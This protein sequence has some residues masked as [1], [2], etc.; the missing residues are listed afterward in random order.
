V[1]GRA[2]PAAFCAAFVSAFCA[3]AFGEQPLAPAEYESLEITY[4][5]LPGPKITETR[6]GRIRLNDSPALPLVSRF[7]L[8]MLNTAGE[9]RLTDLALVAPDGS[10]NAIPTTAPQRS[11]L[12]MFWEV[13]GAKPGDSVR[14]TVEQPVDLKGDKTRSWWFS[15]AAPLPLPVKS[16]VLRLVLPPGFRGTLDVLE[17]DGHFTGET[18]THSWK[19]DGL[20]AGRRAS[21]FLI[22][23][24]SDWEGFSTWVAE[25]CPVRSGDG[26]VSLSRALPTATG[27]EGRAQAAADALSRRL[28]VRPFADGQIGYGCRPVEE[29][30]QAGGANPLEAQ[31]VLV[32]LLREMRIAA[33]GYL[34]GAG[35]SGDLPVNPEKLTNVL[36]GVT[37]NGHVLWFDPMRLSGSTGSA[38]A[39]AMAEF[40]LALGRRQPAIW[41]PILPE[42]PG[43][44]TAKLDAA[45]T[46]RGTLQGDFV[47]TA[48]GPASEVYWESYRLRTDGSKGFTLLGPFLRDLGARSGPVVSDHND[49]GQPFRFQVPIHHEQFLTPIQ[50]NLPVKLNAIPLVEDPKPMPDG[51][52]FIGV[53][54]H[55]YEEIALT[56]P[57]G[58][59]VSGDVRIQEVRDFATYRSESVYAEGKLLIKRELE[60]RT[61]I[62]QASDRLA[63]DA[64][65]QLIRADQSHAFRLRRT[66]PMKVSEWVDSIAAYQAGQEGWKALEEGEYEIAR[67]LLERA[68]QANPKDQYAWNNL[69]RAL[70]AL[71]KI[72]E[73][74][75]AYEKQLEVS[76]K[77]QYAYSYLGLLFARQGY[78]DRAA[79]NYRKQLEVDPDDEYAS[80]NLAEALLESGRWGEA[81]EVAAKAAKAHPGSQIEAIAA[82]A[83]MCASGSSKALDEL[84]AAGGAQRS[85]VALNSAAYALA[86][87]GKELDRA[88][89]YME[90]AIEILE[91]GY[92]TSDKNISELLGFQ[93]AYGSYADTLGWIL[94]RKGEK[95]RAARLI[96]AAIGVAHHPEMMAH[97]ATILWDQGRKAEAARWAQEAVYLAPG[98]RSKLPSELTF[99]PGKPGVTVD[100]AWYPVTLPAGISMTLPADRSLYYYAIAN[101][102]GS[103]ELIKPLD[104]TDVAAASWL[105]Q[106][107]KLPIPTA[108]LEHRL[109]RTVQF[110]KLSN[111]AEGKPALYRSISWEAV[112]TAMEL[113]PEEF[114][115]HQGGESQ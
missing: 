49:V 24:F 68:T 11:G 84:D 27:P 82:A 20:P 7:V 70:E 115:P 65:W 87:C 34:S 67:L 109:F 73:A 28:R 58:F 5:L 4:R 104:G 42:G 114:E 92:G 106:I 108:V 63:L 51:R 31:A 3:L 71:G 76:P 6:T 8:P 83:N 69:G 98:F 107:E 105:E 99:E 91:K 72:E 52:Y 43:E 10:I 39:F 64:L 74:R 66:G 46:T 41:V 44:V 48:K 102:D 94:W 59:A 78:S 57:H 21:R 89:Q 13:A 45:I 26:I 53:P 2:F 77:D 12:L 75:Q 113:A 32:A 22:S 81:A 16:G 9:A 15:D 36:V 101:A 61:A 103:I 47:L 33:G 38:P 60:L 111:T 88:Q 19:L 100:G 54:G 40:A 17:R 56:I 30:L 97:L 23:S 35:M 25:T 90:R 55:R 95:E 62:I 29:V 86:E 50:R 85:T 1:T 110:L 80:R 79:Q 18:L 37:G 112:R 14:F 96:M 93:S